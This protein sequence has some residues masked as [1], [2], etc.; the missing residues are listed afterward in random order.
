M[1]M[2]MYALDGEYDCPS[3]GTDEGDNIFY[4]DKD[5]HGDSFKRCLTCEKCGQEWTEWE[6]YC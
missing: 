1:K 4:F 5:D 6:D 2:T 3:C